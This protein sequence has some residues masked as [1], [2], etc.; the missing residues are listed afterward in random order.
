MYKYNVCTWNWA[1]HPK[2]N[3]TLHNF[4]TAEF[5]WQDQNFSDRLKFR[6]DT[7]LLLVVFP[8]T[9][10]PESGN[11][12]NCRSLSGCLALCYRELPV[13]NFHLLP[14]KS[15]FVFPVAYSAETRYDYGI[16]DSANCIAYTNK[17]SRSCDSR[18][19][20]VRY[21]V[22]YG[23]YI[24]TV[25]EIAVVSMI[26]YLFTVSNWSARLDARSLLLMAV[27]FSGVRCVLW[28]NDTSYSKCVW[29][30]E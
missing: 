10:G 12:I 9:N 17:F 11:T 3:T 21:D 27:S 4:L 22:R 6:V 15:L 14:N 1:L 24:Q 7:T 28:P 18:L 2:E 29:R 16:T 19:Y 26:S 8:L 30:S 5:F 25:S 23:R 20:C 13:V